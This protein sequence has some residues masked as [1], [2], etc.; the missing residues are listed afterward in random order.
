VQSLQICCSVFHQRSLWQEQCPKP[1]RT[2]GSSGSSLYKFTA[3]NK[4]CIRMIN[5]QFLTVA[6][7][8]GGALRL[9]PFQPTIIFHDDIF[10]C[11]T[12]FFS[13]KT[14][15]FRHSVTK[16]RQLP[17]PRTPT[18]ALPLDPTGGLPSPRLSGP[19]PFTHSKYATGFWHVE[20]VRTLCNSNRT[21]L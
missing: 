7:L 19:P 15:K 16:K 10:G 20:N 11:F 3:R 8:G 14:S 1:E 17:S 5:F 6:Y 21:I 13:S 9:P 12:K 18:E 2:V 4:R